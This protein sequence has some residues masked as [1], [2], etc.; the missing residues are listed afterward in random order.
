MTAHLAVRPASRARAA[1]NRRK[2]EARLADQPTKAQRGWMSRRW[3]R[4]DFGRRGWHET[5]N[6]PEV[7]AMARKAVPR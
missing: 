5:L 3:L 1:E 4:G 6:D 2:L 7:Q